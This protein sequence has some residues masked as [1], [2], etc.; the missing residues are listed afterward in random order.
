VLECMVYESVFIYYLHNKMN[1]SRVKCKCCIW[2][3]IILYKSFETNKLVKLVI[4]HLP[5]C[6]HNNTR[7]RHREH[8]LHIVTLNENALKMIRT[9][10]KRVF[11]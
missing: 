10:Y 11:W 6:P 2:R 4:N 1:L 3:Y 7:T 5:V 9:S 8:K